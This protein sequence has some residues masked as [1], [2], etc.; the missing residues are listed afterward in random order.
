MRITP[1]VIDSIS[2]ALKSRGIRRVELAAELGLGP[3]WVTKLLNGDFQVLRESH[4][5]IIERMLRIDLAGV[6]GEVREWSPMARAVAS[7]VDDDPLAYKMG[8]LMLK[9]FDKPTYEQ[10]SPS[11]PT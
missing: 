1:Y 10:T 7:L 4:R 9:L 8:E 5:Q 2:E 11:D 6:V 3:S